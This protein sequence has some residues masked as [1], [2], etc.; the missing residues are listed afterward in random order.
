MNWRFRKDDSD[1]QDYKDI[2]AYTV[3][4]QGTLSHL[5]VFV[6][7]VLQN[8][9]D[10]PTRADSQ[11]RVR[12]RPVMLIGDGKQTFLEA[13]GWSR[14]RPHVAAVREEQRVRSDRNLVS[15]VEHI[16]DLETPLSLLH[17]EDFGTRGLIGP[18]TNQE[19]RTM[20]SRYQGP[21]CF[22]GLCKNTGDNQKDSS[23]SGGIY[24]FGKGVLWKNS[25]IGTVL[26]HS[27]LSVSWSSAAADQGVS[28]RLFGK[29][30]LPQHYV[31]AECFRGE[32]YFCSNPDEDGLELPLHDR[33]AE[34]LARRLGFVPRRDAESGT[35]ILVVDML[36]P[37]FDREG[38]PD[39]EDIASSIRAAAER[40]F[41][42]AIVGRKLAVETAIL[43]ADG[44]ESVR[45]VGLASSPALSGLIQA[46][47]AARNQDSTADVKV[48]SI[49]AT[50]PRGPDEGD[51]E[52]HGELRV[53]TVLRSD[54]P[55]PQELVNRA[56]LVRGTGM[57]VGY[58]R[59][60]RQGMNARDFYCV[61]L[62]GLACSSGRPQERLEKL[63]ALSEPVTHDKWYDKSEALRSWRGARARIRDIM[64]K[65]ARAVSDSTCDSTPPEGEAAPAM[66]KFLPLLSGEEIVPGERSIRVEVIDPGTRELLSDRNVVR[67]K[68]RI[69]VTVPPR[70]EL[71]GEPK[72]SRWRVKV[73]YGFVG[74]GR[75]KKMLSQLSVRFAGVRNNNGEWRDMKGN[76]E[77]ESVFEESVRDVRE[78]WELWGETEEVD[79]TV[80]ATR[81]YTLPIT[82]ELGTHKGG[83]RGLAG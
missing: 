56:A 44:A 54:G 27:R 75:S 17:V 55:E 37:D 40:F 15:D 6:R 32:A 68:F 43:D 69:R 4:S 51:E 72:P 64:A 71:T 10:N 81:K 82:A 78:V 50:V 59:V 39:V 80:D 16:A 8:S 7:E 65:I 70:R 57:V 11:V 53:A 79:A 24:G 67:H 35:S 13:M 23:Y 46:F 58:E 61:V 22:L 3:I 36:Y 38:L 21:H 20:A 30:R 49:P 18:E 83:E 29:T 5:E 14:L 41:W 47:N 45:S 52:A 60:R 66:A 25:G 63:L 77:A 62:G 74:E 48:C 9:L 28:E 73:R 33:E 34:E 12:F 1:S 2:A 76:L 19:A 42:P 31:E 26:F